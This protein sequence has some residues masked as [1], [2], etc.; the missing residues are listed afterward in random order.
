MEIKT[1]DTGTTIYYNVNLK[2]IP[3]GTTEQIILTRDSPFGKATKYGNSYMYSALYS[4]KPVTFFVNESDKGP[5]YGVTLNSLLMQFKRGDILAITKKEGKMKS[6]R[7]FRFFE[8]KKTGHTD[9]GLPTYIKNET[10]Q[11]K[12]N[13]ATKPIINLDVKK[14]FKMSDNEKLVVEAIKNDGT[15]KSYNKEQK[16]QVMVNNGIEYKRAVEIADNQ[17]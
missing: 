5:E 15:A 3:Y 1:N 12:P 7:P 2:D 4:D 14:E 8:V 9:S 11:F 13:L 10:S 17:F 6:G 16:I